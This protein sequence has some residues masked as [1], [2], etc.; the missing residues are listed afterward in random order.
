MDQ[1]KIIQA[2]IEQVRASVSQPL[3]DAD[4]QR[5]HDNVKGKVEQAEKLREVDLANGDE[6]YFTFRPYRAEDAR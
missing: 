1:D 6:P 4:V 2:M 3:D 5:I